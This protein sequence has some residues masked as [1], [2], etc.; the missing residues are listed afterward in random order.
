MSFEMTNCNLRFV[1][2]IPIHMEAMKVRRKVRRQPQ[3]VRKQVREL[4]LTSS[5]TSQAAKP[6]MGASIHQGSNENICF[7]DLSAI[8]AR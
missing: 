8:F 6:S 1:V 2:T 7:C 4:T 5:W 3:K